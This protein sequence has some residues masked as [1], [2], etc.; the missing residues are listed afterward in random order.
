[1]KWRRIPD[2]FTLLELLVAMIITLGLA[3]LMLAVVTNTLGLWQ[4]TQD[5]FSSSAQATLALDMIERDLQ[6]AAFRR[7]GGTWMAVDV[8]STPSVLT[9]HGWLTAGTTKPAGGESQRFLT[10]TAGSSVPTISKA[11]FGLSG[12]WVRFITT[13]VESGGS[14]PI[15]VSYQIARRPLSGGITSG[16]PAAVRYTLFR[17]AVSAENTLASGNDVTVAGYGSA[18]VAPTASRAP[19]TLTNPNNTDALATNVVDFGVWLYVRDPAGLRRIFPADNSDTVHAAHDTGS[20]PDVNRFP[21]VGEVMIRI[22][23][24]HGATVLAEMESG[25]GRVTRPAAYATDAEWWWAVAEANSHVYTRRVEVK[26]TA[27]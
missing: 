19:A 21:D 7:D 17:A 11:R 26:G 4:R 16:N 27:L 10:D 24:E 9:T 12:A 5:N 23:T 14:L 22:L 3:G 15:A 25:N 1:M 20:A 2:G 6:A 8:I 18:S 13:N